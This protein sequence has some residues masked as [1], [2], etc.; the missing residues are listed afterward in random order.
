M[1]F[2]LHLTTLVHSM[3]EQECLTAIFSNPEAF[4]LGEEYVLTSHSAQ[5]YFNATH[6][7]MYFFNHF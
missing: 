3:W 6:T 1:R 4:V 5:F 2:F 7:Q